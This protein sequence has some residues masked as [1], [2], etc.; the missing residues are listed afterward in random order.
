VRNLIFVLSHVFW[1]AGKSTTLS[2]LGGMLSPHSSLTVNGNIVNYDAN[3]RT[4]NQLHRVAWLQQQDRFFSMLTVQETLDIAVFLE[5]PHLTEQ[6]RKSLV[7]AT[8]DSLGLTKVEKRM[9]GD[10][11][12]LLPGKGLS[13]GEQR[14]LSL[15]RELVSSPELFIGDEP[16]SGLD[17]TLSEKVVHQIK[18]LVKER[19]IPCLLSLHQPRSS[20][21][22]MLDDIMLMAPEGRICY[23]GKADQAI[24]YFKN[25]GF[26]CPPMTNPAEFLVDLVSIDSED[27]S[28]ALE[29]EFR[30]S[31][32]EKSFQKHQIKVHRKVFTAIESAVA[33]VDGGEIYK[34]AATD[35][36]SLLS[37][38][39]H[40]L[41]RFRRLLLRSWKQNI[42]NHRVNAIRLIGSAGN[43]FLF[44][45]IFKSIKKGA[46]TPKSVGDRV[47]M[48]SFG[49]INMSMIALL[50][51]VDLFSKERP[52]VQREKMRRQYSSLEYLLSK[53]LA[54]LPLDAAFAAVFTTV[55]KATSGI[56]TGWRALTGTFALMT[57]SG[58]SLGFAI[59]A[60][61]PSAEVAMSTAASLMVI[62]MSVGIINP[63]GIDVSQPQPILV[64]GLK[65]ISPI[66][67][68]IK[69]V[70]VSEYKDM[71]F[72]SE[73]GKRNTLFSRSVLK[74]LPKMGGL[75]LV[76]NGN[77]VLHELGLGNE[78]YLGSMRHLA[79][80]S[81]ANLF[82]SWIGLHLQS[83]G[84]SDLSKSY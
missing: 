83:K 22:R 11:S 78:T 64:Q 9:V 74:D 58:A 27:P 28:L 55:L 75:A 66:N 79:F 14:R 62:L 3:S 15:A 30:I 34:T 35:H 29:D 46:F 57:V 12:I 37:G 70:C 47:A 8:L 72:V 21:F 51:T 43:A 6:Q 41:G 59:G 13:G 5:S 84:G 67:Y 73:N 71:Q 36:K 54:E 32:L 80:L 81:L 69:A 50:K 18:K 23:H 39:H 17:S 33:P 10:P 40:S 38:F 42:R 4:S 24:Q 53:S 82:V 60:W 77:Q 56:Q 20:I 63:S 61:T 65:Q 26:P 31:Q 7:G 16:T 45:T 52:V 49:I 44:S 25:L 68:A 48:L 2:A 19:N 1:K 76:K